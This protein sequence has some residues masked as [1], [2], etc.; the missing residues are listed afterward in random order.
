MLSRQGPGQL[1]HS[2]GASPGAHARGGQPH[3]CRKLISSTRKAP[4]GRERRSFTQ[5]PGAPAQRRVFGLT[6][7]VAERAN[8]E[9]GVDDVQAGE[10]LTS[11]ATRFPGITRWLRKRR[12]L[13]AWEGRSADAG[14]ALHGQP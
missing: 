6:D 10:G 14:S 7:K 5:H 3:R 2:A 9:V 8:R 11:R 13:T 1:D 12:R 4:C